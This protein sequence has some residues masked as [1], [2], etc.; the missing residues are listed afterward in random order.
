MRDAYT[1]DTVQ[2]FHIQHRE[3]PGG[4]WACWRIR[5][6]GRRRRRRR[7]GKLLESGI[8]MDMRACGL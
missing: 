3:N 1:D 4:P 5:R 7:R 6:N 8:Q 2:A